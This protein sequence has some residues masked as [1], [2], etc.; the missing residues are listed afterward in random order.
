MTAVLH[1]FADLSTVRVDT[2]AGPESAPDAVTTKVQVPPRPQKQQP[3]ARSDAP[4]K[5]VWGDPAFMKVAEFLSLGEPM[6]RALVK[7]NLDLR[8]RTLLEVEVEVPG[9]PASWVLFELMIDTEGRVKLCVRPRAVG[10][11]AKL[12]VGFSFFMSEILAN[13]PAPEDRFKA[14]YYVRAMMDLSAAQMM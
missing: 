8:H 10:L 14:T 4:P 2:Q 11:G 13:T 6:V 12:T 7:N 1:S 9:A 3:K 5:M